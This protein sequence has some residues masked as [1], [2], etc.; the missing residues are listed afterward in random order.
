MRFVVVFVLGA[1]AA[2][3]SE[4][5][6][7]S[8]DD[9]GIVDSTEVSELSILKIIVGLHIEGVGARISLP[10]SCYFIECLLGGLSLN[11]V[12]KTSGFCVGFD[13]LDGST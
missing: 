13:V 10:L 11:T 9:Q 3:V 4:G 2:N 5:S 7:S 12:V 6:I 8:E 1:C